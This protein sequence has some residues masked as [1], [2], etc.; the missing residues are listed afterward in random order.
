[1]SAQLSIDHASRHVFTVAPAIALSVLLI[2]CGSLLGLD[3]DVE[4]L[5]EQPVAHC[6]SD[7]EC[8]D[9]NPC[10]IDACVASGS[11]VACQHDLLDD[12]TVNDTPGD[13]QQVACSEGAP[14]EMVD[15]DDV[16]GAEDPCISGSCSGGEAIVVD[17]PARTACGI[18]GGSLCDGKGACVSCIDDRDCEWPASCGG[19]ETQGDCGCTPRSCVELGRTCGS[20]SDGCYDT[21][22]CNNDKVDGAETDEDCGGDVSACPARCENGRS[23]WYG[24]DCDSGLCAGATCD[25]PFCDAF[26]DDNVQQVT[27]V[28]VDADGSV[29]MVG[30][31]LGNVDF[32]GGVLEPVGEGWNAFMFKTSADGSH[33]WSKRFGGTGEQSFSAVAV[34]GAGN[35]AVSA[36]LTGTLGLGAT[37]VTSDLG[38][39]SVIAKFD[40]DGNLLWTRQCTPLDASSSAV[41]VDIAAGPSN[42]LVLAGQLVGSIDCAGSVLTSSA[43]GFDEV[44]VLRLDSAA[45]PTVAR[46]FVGS[47]MDAVGG[48]AV[49]LSGDIAIAGQFSGQIS[50][51]GDVLESDGTFDV[52]AAKFNSS[53]VHLFSKAIHG[54]LDEIA[55]DLAVDES[56]AVVV[57]GDFDG[58]LVFESL[59][60]QSIH[61]R[62]L[63]VARITNDGSHQWVNRFGDTG[64]Q[65]AAAVALDPQG[66]VVVVGGFSGE[67]SMG[68]SSYLSHGSHDAFVAKLDANGVPLWLKTAGDSEMQTVR[69][70]AVSTAG[71]VVVAGDFRGALDFGQGPIVSAG[72]DDVFLASFAP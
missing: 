7:A 34:D 20:A 12:V 54:N 25:D 38:H 4:R 41:G 65:L 40:A 55:R 24:T 19:G 47:G 60:L 18:D 42:E 48:V 58:S 15:D 17:A 9:A 22:D 35:I 71:S 39:S 51:G 36:N 8:D 57:F 67:L 63:F 5:V 27:G 72:D 10:T 46:R 53:G 37:T 64:D 69:A 16:P 21:L 44:F 26:G 14:T 61:G 2:G 28:A 6:A 32:G 1:M 68:A 33:I 3:E 59:E 11:T 43:S 45:T 52:F 66:D 50:L 23:C 56:G 62:D 49:D 70:V 30:R 31:L 29:V 13:C